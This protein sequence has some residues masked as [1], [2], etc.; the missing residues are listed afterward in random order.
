MTFCPVRG[1]GPGVVQELLF[2][3]SGGTLAIDGGTPVRRSAAPVWPVFDADEIASV[4]AILQSRKVNQWTGD[5]V[6]A[7]EHAFARSLDRPHAIAVA[8]GTLALETMLRAYDI[9]A[10]DEVIV[11]PR[12][13]IAGYLLSNDGTSPNTT[14]PST[15]VRPML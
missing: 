13:F 9:G 4:V 2:R 8:N 5:R 11:T 7:F 12:S 10:G 15:Y 14:M 1:W 3:E 6:Q